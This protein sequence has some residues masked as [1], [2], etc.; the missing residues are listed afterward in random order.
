MKAVTII[1]IA[2]TVSLYAYPEY[3]VVPVSGT[4]WIGRVSEPLILLAAVGAVFGLAM[5]N[6]RVLADNAA[7][8][9]TETLYGEALEALETYRAEKES[10]IA[11]SV[12]A[13]MLHDQLTQACDKLLSLEHNDEA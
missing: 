6:A 7:F 5:L 2:A 4:E 11:V 10:T 8:R 9:E 12:E 1:F 3:E 13:Q